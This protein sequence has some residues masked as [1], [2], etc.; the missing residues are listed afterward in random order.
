CG[1]SLRDM[2]DSTIFSNR[3]NRSSS[4]ESADSARASRGV[5]PG[6]G[7]G[8]GAAL[9]TNDPC[10]IS[11]ADCA[12]SGAGAA[13]TAGAVRTDRVGGTGS[14]AGCPGT[15]HEPPVFNFGPEPIA[16][17]LG[18]A[19][20]AASLDAAAPASGEKLAATEATAGVAWTGSSM[21]E[22]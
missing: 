6:L 7:S 10:D 14:T 1:A 8:T 12:V 20:G 19:G 21:R 5:R 22:S 4:V 15:A 2:R 3:S 9:K 18:V 17:G 16:G 13:G 11:G